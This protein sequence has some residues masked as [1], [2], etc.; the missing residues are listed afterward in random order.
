MNITQ[1][2]VVGIEYELRNDSGELLDSSEGEALHYLHGHGNIVEGLETALDGKS[3]GDELQVRVEP[4]QGYGSHQEGLVIEV[5]INQLPEDLTPEVGMTLGVPTED[6]DTVPCRVTKVGA[7]T[8]TLDG[9]HELADVALNFKVSV[10][11]VRAATAE[12][13]DHGHVHGP[14]GHHHH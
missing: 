8:I 14:G 3:V 9:N 7:L 13:L 12:E 5:P 2:S 4:E 6:G 11:S 10:Q 1:N